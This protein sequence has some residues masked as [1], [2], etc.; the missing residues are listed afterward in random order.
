MLHKSQL[1]R[2][3]W[4]EALMHAVYVKNQMWTRSLDNTTPFKL[5]YGVKP[6]L[7]NMHVW[8]SRVWVH[9]KNGMKLDSRAKEGRWVGFDEESKGNQIYWTEK[10]SVTVERSVTFMLGETR[11][12]GMLLEGE[13]GD[14]DEPEEPAAS[15]NP[16]P[17]SNNPIPIKTDGHSTH[18]QRGTSHK[19]TVTLRMDETTNDMPQQLA[20]PT[21]AADENGGCGKHIRKELAYVWHI[22]EGENATAMPQGLQTVL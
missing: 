22:C 8:G 19:T 6:N 16:I 7:S 10:R 20:Q 1:P 11:I 3:L 14:F 18:P 5:L 9:D 13:L 4:G 17:S 2:F 15:D 12:D 21:V